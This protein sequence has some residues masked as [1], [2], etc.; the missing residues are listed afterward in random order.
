MAPAVR[1]EA[2]LA[3]EP[4]LFLLAELPGGMRTRDGR[5]PHPNQAAA[6]KEVYRHA[7]RLTGKVV[8]LIGVT[9]PAR[10]SDL[11][12]RRLPCAHRSGR[13]AARDKSFGTAPPG[14]LSGAPLTASGTG[15]VGPVTTFERQRPPTWR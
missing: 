13:P 12:A 8:A 7:L 9:L 1:P 2:R 10:E 15:Q 5:P 11:R 4:R 14:G 3:T 6:L